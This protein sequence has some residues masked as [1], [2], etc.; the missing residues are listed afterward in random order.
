MSRQ[1]FL[2]VGVAEL[3][4]GDHASGTEMMRP[5]DKVTWSASSV[6]STSMASGSTVK[7]EMLIPLIYN[8]ILPFFNDLPDLG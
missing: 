3:S 4:R 1:F 5:S 6:Q 2:C 8:L 7:T